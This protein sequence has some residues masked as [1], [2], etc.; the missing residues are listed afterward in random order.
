MHTMPN[1]MNGSAPT[2]DAE[3]LAHLRPPVDRIAGCLPTNMLIRRDAFL[4]VGEFATDLLARLDSDET[5]L[6]ASVHFAATALRSELGRAPSEREVLHKIQHWKR[7]RVPPLN[8]RDVVAA[9]RDLAALGW[10]EVTATDL[11]PGD[12][13]SVA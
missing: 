3:A 5:E 1:T 8:D 12:A 2:V 9:I 7:R 13:A 4:R 10:I 6:A 11:P